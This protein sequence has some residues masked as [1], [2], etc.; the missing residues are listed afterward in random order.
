[1]KRKIIK[2]GIGGYT[3]YLP[4]KWVDKNNLNKDQEIDIIEENNDLI[5]KAK[6]ESKEKEITTEVDLHEKSRVRTLL[7]SL[8]RRGYTL[9]TLTSKLNFSY[10]EINEIVN[11]LLG[12]I[13]IEESPN[14]I[15][16]K[17]V[18]NQ[19]F[20]EVTKIITKMIFTIKYM[21]DE[22]KDNYQNK[23]DNHQQI[24]ELKK[25]LIKLRDYCQRIINITT[26]QNDKSYEFYNLIFSIE[27]LSGVFHSF[28]IHSIKD[29]KTKQIIEI[30]DE[31]INFLIELNK[32]LTKNDI[33]LAIKINSEV[34]KKRLEYTKKDLTIPSVL[35]EHLFSISSRIVGITI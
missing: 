4:K 31:S 25:N 1:M 7:S 29:K 2:Q 13:I 22:I 20:E 8:Y 33:K 21:N 30:F 17:N 23:K 26:Y 27:K 35:Y 12:C 34:S 3:I 14:K 32:A 10:H 24:D 15:I 9:I 28:H 19:E 18:M 11:S 16:I 6:P 5:I